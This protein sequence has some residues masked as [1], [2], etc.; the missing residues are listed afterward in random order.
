METRMSISDFIP[1]SNDGANKVFDFLYEKSKQY[2][3]P[4]RIVDPDITLKNIAK[5]NSGDNG[6]IK[7]YGLQ[8]HRPSVDF[9]S[10]K[11]T[12]DDDFLK[13]TKNTNTFYVDIGQNWKIINFQDVLNKIQIAIDNYYRTH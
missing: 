11:Y 10:G 2:T 8:D 4:F 1:L 6:D 9:G 12:F 7:I 5:Y 13:S 3:E